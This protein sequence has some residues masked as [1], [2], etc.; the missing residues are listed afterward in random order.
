MIFWGAVIQ[1][2]T[3]PEPRDPLAETLFPPFFTV[4]PA[5]FGAVL[6]QVQ[7]G[8]GG[9]R[10]GGWERWLLFGVSQKAGSYPPYPR[11]INVL[12]SKLQCP[13]PQGT[14]MGTVLFS[15]EL[16]MGLMWLT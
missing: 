5:T 14:G 3:V 10:S 4:Q 2:S 7:L 9:A 12:P 11:K 16:C 13:R 15:R 6:L 1:P 8:A